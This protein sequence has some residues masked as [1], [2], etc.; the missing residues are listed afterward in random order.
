MHATEIRHTF[1]GHVH[2]PQLYHL[3]STG[4]IADFTP[5]AGV[6]VP[7]PGAPAVAGV[8]GLVRAAA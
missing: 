4:K 3:S 5:V 8:A 2:Q 7:V 6:A 1:C